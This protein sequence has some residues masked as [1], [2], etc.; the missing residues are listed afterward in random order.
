VVDK[1]N[2]FTNPAVIADFK[3][4]RELN[5]DATSNFYSFTNS[6]TKKSQNLYLC[7]IRDEKESKEKSEE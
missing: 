5:F 1:P 6:R 7:D 3:V 2:L 4:P